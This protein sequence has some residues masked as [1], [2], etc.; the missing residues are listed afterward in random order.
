M[1]PTPAVAPAAAAG[2][3]AAVRPPPEPSRVIQREPLIQSGIFAGLTREQA[4]NVAQTASAGA[5]PAAVMQQIAQQ[6]HQNDVLR[7]QAAIHATMQANEDYNRRRQYEQDLRACHDLQRQAEEDRARAAERRTEEEALRKRNEA[8]TLARDSRPGNQYEDTVLRL[9][10]KIL[11]GTATEAERA[12]YDLHLT[13]LRQGSLEWVSN[14]NIPGGGMMVRVPREVPSR[15]PPA[16]YKLG[17][18]L[19]GASQSVVRPIPGAT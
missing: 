3:S 2:C 14:P 18:P 11:D 17:D 13:A 8:A 5:K 16:D 4:I 7:Q 9:Y 12:L 15:F 19:P 1:P 6:R 10:P